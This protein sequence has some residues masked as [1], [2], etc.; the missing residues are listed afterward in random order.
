MSYRIDRYGHLIGC[1]SSSFG[2]SND[3]VTVLSEYRTAVEE[4]QELKHALRRSEAVNLQYRKQIQQCEDT[5]QA[6]QKRLSEYEELLGKAE[7]MAQLMGPLTASRE[8]KDRVEDTLGVDLDH[9]DDNGNPEPYID[10]SPPMRAVKL[11]LLN[12]DLDEIAQNIARYHEEKGDEEKYDMT[13]KK[14]WDQQR[15]D[16]HQEMWAERMKYRQNRWDEMTPVHTV[17]Q[18]Q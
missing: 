5:I 14:N 7:M 18:E 3:L 9:D 13:V 12:D 6:M 2:R 15:A 8:D 4:N 17:L 11:A 16:I 1:D 10:P